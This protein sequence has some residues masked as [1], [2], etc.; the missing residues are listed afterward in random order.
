MVRCPV[1]FQNHVCPVLS[2][3]LSAAA[4]STGGLSSVNVPVGKYLVAKG[5][6]Q[7]PGQTLGEIFLGRPEV[8]HAECTSEQRLK[9]CGARPD[10]RV[11]MLRESPRGPRN[12]VCAFYERGRTQ[13]LKLDADPFAPPYPCENQT[14]LQRSQT[15]QDRKL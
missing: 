15:L 14:D 2:R 10:L 8:S 7:V 6:G 4:I 3:L 1:A 11:S 13:F 5:Y 12:T 9:V